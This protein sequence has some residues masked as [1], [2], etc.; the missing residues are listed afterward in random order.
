MT[1]E[2]SAQTAGVDRENGPAAPSA[3]LERWQRLEK[4]LD[5]LQDNVTEYE[6]L[7]AK[8]DEFVDRL[9]QE[10]LDARRGLL[11]DA[12]SPLIRRLL[13]L[14]DDLEGTR[15]ESRALPP[16]E[17]LASVAAVLRD[18]L[19]SYGIEFL[20]PGAG[21]RFDSKEMTAIAFHDTQDE[22]LV[23]CVVA[24]ARQGVRYEER[25]LRPAEVEV[26]RRAARSADSAI[27]AP[28][29][30]APEAMAAEDQTETQGK[31]S[32]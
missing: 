29:A 31:N 20:A 12:I 19:A 2:D 10:A 4:K 8:R 14:L 13:F 16:E 7:L 11:R 30:K 1:P 24:V 28:E 32:T 25:L 26:W 15:G 3:D 27:K 22:D 18:V 21:Q 23:D 5:R 9:H 6:R 17:R